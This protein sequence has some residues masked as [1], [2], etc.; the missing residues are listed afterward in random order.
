[1][2]LLYTIHHRRCNERSHAC[3]VTVDDMSYAYAQNFL[4]SAPVDS[5]CS[6]AGPDVLASYS[7][8]RIAPAP[9]GVS[10]NSSLSKR[11]L[12]VT[13]NG[14]LSDVS[15]PL[16]TCTP[17]KQITPSVAIL[18]D[19]NAL[20]ADFALTALNAVDPKF[21][22]RLMSL[23]TQWVSMLLAGVEGIPLCVS[24]HLCSA[25]GSKVTFPYVYANRYHETFFGVDRMHLI[26]RPIDSLFDNEDLPVPDIISTKGG[27][28]DQQHIVNSFKCAPH[29][30]MNTLYD[31]VRGKSSVVFGKMANPEM[32]STSRFANYVS[33]ISNSIPVEQSVNSASDPSQ[34]FFSQY[35]SMMPKT[36]FRGLMVGLKP[37]LSADKSTVRFIFALQQE[38]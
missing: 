9:L 19:V 22:P 8:A 11:S 37:V 38:V 15:K 29:P 32:V 4:E 25:P 33:P 13:S 6:Y 14:K 7:D 21:L 16:T 31:K 36:M 27:E 34:Q 18:D 24:M 23:G 17:E 10:F 35:E 12:Y 30:S 5:N 26:G 20:H 1:M 28:G 2:R 3:S